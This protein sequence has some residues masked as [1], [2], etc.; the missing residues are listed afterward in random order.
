[1]G[2]HPALI[3][4]ADGQ[5]LE[6]LVRQ[7]PTTRYIGEVGLDFSTPSTR[8]EQLQIFKT[9]LQ[10]CSAYGNKVLSV[11]SRRAVPA[12]LSALQDFCGRVILHWY[13][14]S[15]A[16]LRHAASLGCFFSVNHTM[17]R[18]KSGRAIISSIPRDRLL[19][20]SD[21]PYTPG[22]RPCYQ[23]ELVQEL[24]RD[25]SKLLNLSEQELSIL[26]RENFKSLLQES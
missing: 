23:P 9:I 1:M 2:F 19:T 22:H 10:N 13:S 18:S 8:D 15:I 6:L 3:S 14:G 7:L 4:Q 12:I 16:D 20:E 24:R 21:A 11:H 25:L 5:E 17:L 26:L